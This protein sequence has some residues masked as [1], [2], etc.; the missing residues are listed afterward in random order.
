VLVVEA[1]HIHHHGRIEPELG[2]AQSGALE[3]MDASI[4][5]AEAGAPADATVSKDT[6]TGG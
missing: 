3:P 1:G 6:P 4:G 2:D 5:T